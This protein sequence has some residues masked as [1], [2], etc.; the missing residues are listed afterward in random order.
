MGRWDIPK[1]TL[2]DLAERAIKKE[3]WDK[4]P[5][6]I[7]ESSFGQFCVYIY[8]SLEWHMGT[9]DAQFLLLE[10]PFQPKILLSAQEAKTI[11]CHFV[12]DPVQWQDDE[13]VFIE[14]SILGDH[15]RHAKLIGDLK[16]E[17]FTFIPLNSSWEHIFSVR[18]QKILI[19]HNEN[20]EKSSGHEYLNAVEIPIGKCTWLPFDKFNGSDQ[21][22]FTGEFGDIVGYTDKK[23]NFYFGKPLW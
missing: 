2:K 7:K 17:L 1:Q 9:V 11:R 10:N 13:F 8:S 16:K 22:F 18:D 5:E 3:D 4:I 15:Y 12:I 19:R 21:R 23:L 14:V 20:F 6:F